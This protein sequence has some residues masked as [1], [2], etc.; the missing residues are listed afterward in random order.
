MEIKTVTVIGANGA[1]GQNISGIFASFGNAKVYM[2]CRNLEAAQK[3]KEKA[4][5][6]VKAET[7]GENLI[8]MTYDD[9]EICI[10]NSDLV[11]ESVAENFEIKKEVY[12]RIKKYINPNTIVGT[13]TSGLSINRLSECFD[14]NIRQNFM[15]IHMFNPPY[16]MTLCE[17]IP[18]K[19]TDKDV[20]K[21]IKEYLSNKLFRKVVQIKD[22]PGFMGNRI[23]FQFIN[24][25]L[26]YAEIHKEKGGIDY[27]DSILGP[28]TGRNMAPLA[29]TDFV[30]LD[31]HKAIVDNVYNNTKDYAHNTFITPDYVEMLI[32]E[33]KLGRK[34]GCGLYKMVVNEDGS[35][36]LNVY[37]I[38]SDSYREKA[39]YYFEFASKMKNA[40]KE[41]NYKNAF[42]IL[43]DDN[44]D[45]AKICIQF[46]IKYV[47][48]SLVTTKEIGETIHDADDVMATGFNWIPPLAVIDAFG[49]IEDFKEIA[50][51][52]LDEDY[53]S[54]VDINRILTNI[55]NSNYDFRPFFKAR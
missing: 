49:G 53:L 19:Y 20:L 42:K 37:D 8:P 45:E 22:A 1:M 50:I 52:E 35:K 3:A 2:V 54:V 51:K 34:S 43:F 25:V 10:P 26:Q 18:S 30:G 46:L 41:G 47:I 5:L 17:I 23:G 48:Y 9:L 33:G 32:S 21:N 28:F 29:T 4:S 14:E 40:F 13:G 16:N 7:I 15:G 36:V 11:F 12:D 31:I 55:P 27:I 38:A 24:E 44:S 6:S 39:K